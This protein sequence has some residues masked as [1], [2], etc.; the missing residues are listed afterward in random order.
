MNS[1]GDTDMLRLYQAV[2]YLPFTASWVVMWCKSCP[3]VDINIFYSIY[4]RCQNCIEMLAVIKSLPKLIQAHP[5]IQLLVIDSISFH[6][7]HDFPD[8]RERAK[9]TRIVTKELIQPAV[10]HKMAV[11]IS[12]IPMLSRNSNYFRIFWN[13]KDMQCRGISFFNL[14][15]EILLQMFKVLTAHFNANVDILCFANAKLTSVQHH[16]KQ[17][18]AGISLTQQ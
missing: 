9:L 15:E 8:V 1:W 16:W 13:K 14:H 17:C 11:S 4:F 6:F 3:D 12:C 10:K 18:G 2:I 5:K 7:R